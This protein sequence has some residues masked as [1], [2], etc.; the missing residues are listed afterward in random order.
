MRKMLGFLLR[1]LDSAIVKA[2]GWKHIPH[3]DTDLMYMSIYK[4]KGPAITLSDGT[5]VKRGD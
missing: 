4:Y 5:A 1:R 3:S 2:A